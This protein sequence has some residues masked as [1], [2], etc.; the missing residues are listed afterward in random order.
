MTNRTVIAAFARLPFTP[1][2]RGVGP[3][4][5]TLKA[6]ARAGLVGKAASLL[7]REKGKYALA[8]QC[9]GGGQGIATILEAV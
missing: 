3:V 7:H 8:M 6:L 4:G 5:A 1:A 2:R 9:I